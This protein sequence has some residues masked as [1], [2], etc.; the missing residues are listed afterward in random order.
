MAVPIS[1]GKPTHCH[2][3]CVG[4]DLLPGGGG[5][6]GWL[7]LCTMLWIP[8]RSMLRALLSHDNGH[9]HGRPHFL[10]RCCSIK[11]PSKISEVDT[12]L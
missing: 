4:L 12:D 3:G 5:G 10:K 1:A 8:G 2:S 9:L 6:G 7:D 11:G